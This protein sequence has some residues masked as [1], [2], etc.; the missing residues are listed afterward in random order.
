MKI[1]PTKV[2]GML[3]YPWGLM[4]I[5]SPWLFHF[6]DGGAKMIIPI[7]LGAL[8]LL[9]SIMTDYELGV[10][11]VFSMRMHLF[12]DIVSAVFLAASPW[13]FGFQETVYKP[14]LWIGII[15]LALSLMTSTK[16]GP[17]KTHVTY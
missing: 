16:P 15:Q 1:I 8:M 2:H 14:H 17:V 4:L 9:G 13:I 12:L 11:R 10:F 5:S 6:S 3:D 7:V